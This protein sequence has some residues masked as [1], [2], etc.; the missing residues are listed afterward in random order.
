LVDKLEAWHGFVRQPES[1]E[2]SPWGSLLYPV[3]DFTGLMFLITFSILWW[4]ITFAPFAFLSSAGGAG[5]IP[6]RLFLPFSLGL[7]V[8]FGYTLLYLGEILI[9]SAAGEVRHPHWPDGDLYEIIRGLF[10]WFWAFLTG[11]LLGAVP[12]VLYWIYCGDLDLVDWIV[13]VDLLVPGLAYG[14]MALVASL[15]FDDPLASNPITVCQALWRVGW[16]SI[17]PALILSVAVILA[18]GL[19]VL[20]LAI[21]IPLL[22]FA[23]LWAFWV[24]VLYESMVV[25]RVMGLEYRRQARKLGWFHASP[26]R[27]N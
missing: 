24:F 8:V 19:S 9:S 25:M 27:G 12:S 17:R 21:P 2:T 22:A 6:W 23:S 5:G 20:I 11:A 13:L 1:P 10:R 7:L 3:W 26:R 15:L 4:F 14:Q 18:G 16:G